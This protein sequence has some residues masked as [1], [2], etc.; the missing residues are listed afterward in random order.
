MLRCK[1]DFYFPSYFGISTTCHEKD[2]KDL[3]SSNICAYPPNF[4]VY[5]GYGGTKLNS[6]CIFLCVV[7]TPI[8]PF[9][10]AC[11]AAI[12]A[13]ITKLPP[14]NN[15]VVLSE[16]SS[17]RCPYTPGIKRGQTIVLTHT[18]FFLFGASYLHFLLFCSTHNLL[19]QIQIR[20]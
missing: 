6:V 10:H 4:P 19:L 13:A 15:I 11:G 5:Y 14:H 18:H 9:G 8:R 20:N 1:L 12:A 2:N 7:Y 3:K 16:A 17:P